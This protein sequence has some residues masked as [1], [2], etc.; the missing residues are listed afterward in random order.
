MSALTP[1]R[2]KYVARANAI[3]RS[4]Y[5]DGHKTSVSLENEFWDGLCE[6][7]RHKNLTASALVATIASG[8]NRN[9]LSS[10][11]RVFVLN[12]FRTQCGQKI[13]SNE[14]DSDGP[15]ASKTSP[16]GR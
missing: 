10:A 5:V 7:A 6:V 1:A 14:P 3:K 8:R 11:V 15:T 13:L 16:A 4:V 9:N 2:K 12:H